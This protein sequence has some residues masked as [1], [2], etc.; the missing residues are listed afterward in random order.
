MTDKRLGMLSPLVS[1][2]TPTFNHERYI[3]LCVESVLRQSFQ[4]WEQIII[5]DGST[6]GTRDVIRRYADPRIQYICQENQGIEAL[7]H[8]YNRAFGLCRGVF[9]AILE[10]DDLWPA[11]KLARLMP[12]FDDP[13]VVLAYGLVAELSADGSGGGLTRSVRRRRKLPRS[14]LSN[15][16]V[17]SATIYMLSGNDLVPPSTAIIRRLTLEKIRGFQ[18]VPGLCVTDFPTFLRL[19]LEGTFHYQDQV[20]G[21][22]RRHVK[23]VTLNNSEKISMAA[24]QHGLDFVRQYHLQL[25]VADCN[26]ISKSWRVTTSSNA[27]TEGRFRL[28][29]RDWKQA[30]RYFIRSADL[31]QPRILLASVWGWCLSWLH[32]NLEWV[33]RA[34]RRAAIGE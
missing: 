33:F 24:Y 27:F 20:M 23:S 18:H 17:G 16:P 25:S 9:V 5:D 11:D 10:G 19:S 30:R 3:G 13:T 29:Q 15:T 12:A 14:L 8:T 1:I 21:F 22:R 31:S 7:P 34:A 6:D 4:N 26:A 32:C 2:I 28:V